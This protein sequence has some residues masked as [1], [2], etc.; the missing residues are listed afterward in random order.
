MEAGLA[1]L[2]WANSTSPLLGQVVPQ[3]VPVMT[4]HLSGLA[5]ADA[6]IPTGSTLTQTALSIHYCEVYAAPIVTVV[7]AKTHGAATQ[8]VRGGLLIMEVSYGLTQQGKTVN[9]HVWWT[10][11]IP[12]KHTGNTEQISKSSVANPLTSPFVQYW[13]SPTLSTSPQFVVPQ[14]RGT[15]ALHSPFSQKNQP[16][17]NTTAPR[18]PPHPPGRFTTTTS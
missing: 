14:A 15:W 8:Q 3:T 12:V 7:T 17:V 2:G 13:A 11:T 1:Q 6:I 18:L 10:A 9:W 5:T 16:A 4:L